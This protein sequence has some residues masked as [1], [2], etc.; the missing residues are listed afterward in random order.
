M[1]THCLQYGFYDKDKQLVATQCVYE[2]IEEDCISL[3][4]VDNFSKRWPA[5]VPDTC[6]VSTVTLVLRRIPGN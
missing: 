6:E 5:I 3:L 2:G 4:A 1:V